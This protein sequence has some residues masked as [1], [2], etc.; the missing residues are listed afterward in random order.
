MVASVQW[1]SQSIVGVPSDEVLQQQLRVGEVAG[2]VVPALSVDS[3]QSL[4]EVG[5]VPDPLLHLRAAEKVLTL[6]DKLIGSH[7]NVLIEQVASKDLLSVFEVLHLGLRKH[8]SEHSLGY[9]M[10]VLVVEEKVVVIK[11]QQGGQTHHHCLRF[12]RVVV[13]VQVGHVI[14]PLGIVRVQEHSFQRE[15]RSDSS[16]H[17]EQVE[18]LLDGL[19][20]LLSHTSVQRR[21]GFEMG[22]YLWTGR[23]PSSTPR[24]AIVVKYLSI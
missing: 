13:H 23:F 19:V 8:E 6:L 2:V 4:L 10:V 17:I 5:G 21:S 20:S 24:R 11:E 12:V 1:L 9:E 7:L 18:H 22:T 15:L 16:D 14:V 3:D